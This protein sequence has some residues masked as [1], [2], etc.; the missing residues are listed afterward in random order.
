[1][2]YKEFEIIEPILNIHRASKGNDDPLVMWII[3]HES[4]KVILMIL[5]DRLDD[6]AISFE[7]LLARRTV[8]TEDTTWF[9]VRYCGQLRKV[10]CLGFMVLPI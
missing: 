7:K 2:T 1:M 9:T 4:L 10:H 8:P 3:T 5:K 6:D